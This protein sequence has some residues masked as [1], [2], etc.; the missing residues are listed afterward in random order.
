LE[1]PKAL[2]ERA[3]AALY[4]AK[5][6]GRNRSVI[7]TEAAGINITLNPTLNGSPT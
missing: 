3:D 5:R 6:G 2:V 4:E 7:A 1:S